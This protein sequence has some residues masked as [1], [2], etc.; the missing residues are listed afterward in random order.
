MSELFFHEVNRCLNCAKP[1]C[2]KG[3]PLGNDYSKIIK[4]IKEDNYKQAVAQIGHPFGEI[5]GYVCPHGNACQ[6]GCVLAGQGSPVMTALIERELFSKYPY[7]IERK[8]TVLQ[9]KNYAVIGGGISGLTFACK[10]YENGADITVFECDELLSTIKLIPDFRLPKQAVLRAERA[11]LG[12]INLV[13]DKMDGKR[14]KS[15]QERFAA[16][17]VSTGAAADF[18]LGIDGQAFAVDYRDCLKGNF[19]HGTVAIVG[20]GNSALDCARYA[21]S[22]GC[23]AIVVYRRSQADMPAF[24]TEVQAAVREGV[25]FMFNTAPISLQKADGHLCLTLAKTVNEGRGKLVITDETQTLSFNSV[26]AAIG[27]KFDGSILSAEKKAD[28]YLQYGNVYI[29][30]D[31]KQGKLAVDAVKDGMETVRLITEKERK[32]CL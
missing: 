26:I 28:T 10:A 13:R 30:G 32:I 21:K 15:L 22:V 1:L 7:V 25:E 16:V 5:C 11:F 18:N 12:K 29:G 23:R 17:Y 19:T 9:G 14:L 2:V 3:C 24:A 6:G 27:S 20:G 4:Y 8:D 31:A